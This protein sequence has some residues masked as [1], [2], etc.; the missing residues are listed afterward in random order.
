MGISLTVHSYNYCCWIHSLYIALQYI[1]PLT[2]EN[3]RLSP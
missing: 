2:A 1:Y 3:R